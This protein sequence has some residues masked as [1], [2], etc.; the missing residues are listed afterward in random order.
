MTVNDPWGY[1]ASLE[2]A[3]SLPAAASQLHV[4]PAHPLG[5]PRRSTSTTPRRA[6]RSASA[7]RR[8]RPRPRSSTCDEGSEVDARQCRSCSGSS[9]PSSPL[10]AVVYTTWT[11]RQL[12]EQWYTGMEWVGTVALAVH[13]D[14]GGASSRSTSGGCTRRRAASSPK[15][16]ST[17]NI[18]DG[19]P[20]LGLLQPVELV[21]DR[22][23]RL[24]ARS[25]SSGS[26]SDSGSRSSASPIVVVAIVGWVYE[27][28]RGNFAR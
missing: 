23:R 5:A 2:W 3:T 8:T 28:Y 11:R 20:E 27:Y 6:S 7:R 1:G 22:A 24:G 19:D 16:A 13:R 26:R 21:A 9:R 4:D 10:M 14:P 12:D 25:G 18:D 17:P 15:T